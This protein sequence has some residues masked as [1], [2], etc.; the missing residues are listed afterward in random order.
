[1]SIGLDIIRQEAYERATTRYRAQKAAREQRKAVPAQRGT[2]LGNGTRRISK[3]E[4]VAMIAKKH[5]RSALKLLAEHFG[6][7]TKRSQ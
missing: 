6:G 5:P 4:A 3:E 2:N 7:R 1:M